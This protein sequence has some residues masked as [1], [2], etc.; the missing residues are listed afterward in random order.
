[1]MFKMNSDRCAQFPTEIVHTH[2]LRIPNIPLA[3]L[4]HDHDTE[5]INRNL[6]YI[7][8]GAAPEPDRL[9]AVTPSN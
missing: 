2:D 7:G 1:M 9:A 6:G 5:Y 8:S 4:N 3:Y